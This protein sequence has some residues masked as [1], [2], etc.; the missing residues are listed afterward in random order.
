[1]RAAIK[2]IEIAKEHNME[3]L[4]LKSDSN[5]VIQGATEWAYNGWKL[6][7]E[8]MLRIKKSGLSFSILCMVVNSVSHGN[9]LQHI[10]EY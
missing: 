9:T 6:Q 5:Y 2:A 4:I 3:T 1:M 8:K 7:A 10:L